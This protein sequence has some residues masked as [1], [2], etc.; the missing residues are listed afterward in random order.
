MWKQLICICRQPVM[1]PQSMS[2]DNPNPVYLG[3][4][5][6]QWGKNRVCIKGK[7]DTLPTRDAQGY[8]LRGYDI[9]GPPPPS[10]PE[11]HPDRPLTEY[12]KQLL[13]ELQ[14]LKHRQSST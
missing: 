4:S 1:L 2:R 8:P 11:R 9:P 13:Q 10:T 12:E 7:T 5:K 6:K 3:C 14:D